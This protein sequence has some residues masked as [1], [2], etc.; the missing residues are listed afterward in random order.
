MSPLSS[1]CAI[2]WMRFRGL[3]LIWSALSWSGGCTRWSSEVPSIWDTL[4]YSTL[5]LCVIGKSCTLWR[6]LHII[7]N[8]SL[9]CHATGSRLLFGC[10]CRLMFVFPRCIGLLRGHSVCAHGWWQRLG[11]ESSS[12]VLWNTSHVA[13]ALCYWA[14]QERHFAWGFLKK[15]KICTHNKFSLL[16]MA[17][18]WGQ[19]ERSRHQLGHF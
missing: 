18:G 2:L 11:M 15:G 14:E 17:L 8:S 9:Q 10:E 1:L 6:L 19:I 3:V 12:L 13:S 16:V 5:R 4:F 7:H